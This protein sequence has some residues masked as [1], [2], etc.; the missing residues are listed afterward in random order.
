MSEKK[1]IILHLDMDHFYTAT[2][3]REHPKLK[4]KPVIVGADP[5]E[6]KGRGV[7][8][9]CNYEARKFGVRSGMPISK[10]WKLS[11]QAVYLRPN[12]DLY[13]KVSIEIMELLRGY[14]DKFEQWGID[15]AFLDVTSR[16][17]DYS[18]AEIFARQIKKDILEKQRLTCSIGIGPNKL[19]AKIASDFQKPD[20]LTIVKA[21]DAESFLAPLPVRKLLWVGRKTE[22]KLGVMGIK[23]IGDIA[24]YDPA[25]LV[26][27]FGV[28]GTQF[29]L[30]A[31]GI[32]TSE[33]EERQGIKSTSRDVTFEEDTTDFQFVLSTLDRLSEEVHSDVMRQN[34]L[35][36]TVT[37]RVRYENFETHT[38]GKSLPHMTNRL[39][40]LKKTARELIQPYFTPNRKIRLISVRVSNFTSTEK[41][42]TLV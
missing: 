12:F 8:H 36:R 5:K 30:M 25:V 15:E 41:Q 11:P 31:H 13:L 19:V 23:T 32:D 2:E 29:Y 42:K 7:V 39:Q 3:E 38:H 1:R 40:D 16:V 9:T 35:F 4:G 18:E 27:T 37:I 28:A 6:G 24:H 26:E 21:E 22:H 34:L 14:A 33:V 20:G 17:K 10:A